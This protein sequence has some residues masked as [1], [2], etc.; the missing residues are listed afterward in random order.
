M[1]EGIDGTGRKNLERQRL[2]Q[3]GNKDGFVSI[4][5]VVGNSFLRVA[6]DQGHDRYIGN[7]A[8]S[9]A[10]RRDENELFGFFYGNLAIEQIEDRAD[11]L[12]DE[13]LAQVHDC[14]AADTDDALHVLG[15]IFIN[16]FGHFI[17]RFTHAI[18]FLEQD[19]AR[20]A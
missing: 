18:L 13:Q 7:F 9:P 20:K 10:R 4:Q 17:R 1:D 6:A 11:L 12:Q 19:V 14:T 8:A 2:Q 15:H 16:S 5:S 3:L